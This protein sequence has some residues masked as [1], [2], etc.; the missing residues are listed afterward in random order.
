MAPPEIQDENRVK[1]EKRDRNNIVSKDLVKVFDPIIY[2]V[3]YL[4]AVKKNRLKESKRI[5]ETNARVADFRRKNA[6]L[7]GEIKELEAQRR[8]YER[9]IMKKY[10]E[11]VSIFKPDDTPSSSSSS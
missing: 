3:Y 6:R 9:D 7:Q 10:G 5:A 4:Q 2:V 8:R 11:N 1:Q